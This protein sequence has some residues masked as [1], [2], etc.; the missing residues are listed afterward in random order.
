MLSPFEGKFETFVK[1]T[2]KVF[3]E[4][5]R[6]NFISWSRSAYAHWSICFSFTKVHSTVYSSIYLSQFHNHELKASPCTKANWLSFTARLQFKYFENMVD[7][8]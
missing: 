1:L 5:T 3:R 7:I 6:P 8:I 4:L 2:V